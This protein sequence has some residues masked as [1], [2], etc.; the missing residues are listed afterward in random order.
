MQQTEVSFGQ[1]FHGVL[2]IKDHYPESV[3]WESIIRSLQ[4]AVADMAQY[5]GPITS[6]AH[7]LRKLSGFLHS[8]LF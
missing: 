6:V 4:W 8:G 2:C 7:I 1:W 3:V 5:M